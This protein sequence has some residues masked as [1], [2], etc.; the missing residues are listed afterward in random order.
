MVEKANKVIPIVT[1]HA[2]KPPKFLFIFLN[3]DEK[4]S[5]VNADP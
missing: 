4:A 2:P 3:A 1:S 5:I